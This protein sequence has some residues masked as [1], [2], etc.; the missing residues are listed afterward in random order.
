MKI[1]IKGNTVRYR[2]TRSEVDA[3]QAHGHLEEYTQFISNTMTYAIEK[4]D[5]PHLTADLTQ[6]KITLSIPAQVLQEWA[7]TEKVGMDHHMPLPDGGSLYL[8]LE[9]DFKCIDGDMTDD[10]SDYFENPHLTC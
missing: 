10:Q 9:K 7:T 3:L 1:R 8:L 5:T 6:N 4:A 2:L